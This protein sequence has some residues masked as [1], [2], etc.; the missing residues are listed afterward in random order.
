MPI[1]NTVQKVSKSRDNSQIEPSSEL[2]EK[3]CQGNAIALKEFFEIYSQDIYNF[4]LKVFHLD[5]EAASD[6]FLYAYERLANGSR[7]RSFQGR[8]SFRTW[9]Y[10]VLRNLVIDWMRTLREL[11]TVDV[12]RNSDWDNEFDLISNVIDPRS[13]K[14]EE[15]NAVANF[16]KKLSFIPIEMRVVLKLSY[17]YYLDMSSEE[18]EYLSA[19][20]NI[21]KDQIMHKI[22]EL[23]HE[24]SEKEVKNLASEDKI[25]SLYLS[26][27][28][29]KAKKGKLE[30]FVAKQSI[31]DDSYV[32]E[33][34][35]IGQSIHKKYEQRKR[36]LYKKNRGHFMVR[37]PYKK[38][39][40]LIKTSEGNVSV[41]MMRIMER[42]RELSYTG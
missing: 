19:R 27:L 9:F 40:N 21:P 35:R 34:E 42:L 14:S 6:F 3:C 28:E 20:S 10:A 33:L 31:T 11:D 22:F 38:V 2:I 5:E 15:K 4:P 12:N 41:Q 23:R 24:L 8:S 17:V 1:N 13:I 30:K 36:L 18:I 25:T 39:A 26:I 37:T 32:A 7:L 16:Y 29:L